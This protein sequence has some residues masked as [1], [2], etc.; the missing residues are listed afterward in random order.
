MISHS[1]GLERISV[2]RERTGPDAHHPIEIVF[3]PA[4]VSSA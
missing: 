3:T 4:W 2:K 1:L